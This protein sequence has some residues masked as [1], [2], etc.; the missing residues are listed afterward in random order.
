MHRECLDELEKIQAR[1]DV[2]AND[3]NEEHLVVELERSL[4]AWKS[5][6]TFRGGLKRVQEWRAAMGFPT[7]D[8]S[9]LERKT[10]KAQAAIA[11]RTADPTCS[12]DRTLPKAR[13]MQ[14]DGNGIASKESR[15]FDG[16]FPHQ[17][18]P[19]RRLLAD[20]SYLKWDPPKSNAFRYL[21]LPA[22]NMDVSFPFMSILQATN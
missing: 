18:I 8:A 15:Q 7:R 9:T 12:R 13:V 2:L 11:R 6:E 19:V 20:S 16:W 10:A 14:F 5:T 22:N 1:R 4:A 3:P 17:T 21:H